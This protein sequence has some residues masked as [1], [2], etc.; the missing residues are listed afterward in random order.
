MLAV[1][2]QKGE[3]LDYI[4]AE[5]VSAGDVVIRSSLVGIAKLDIKRGTLGALAVTGVFDV[6]KADV[7]FESGDKVY[8]NSQDKKATKTTTDTYMGLAV[9]AAVKGDLFVRILLNA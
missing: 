4:P 6:A 1:Y 2:V 8:W 3:S 9:N 7:A 5:D